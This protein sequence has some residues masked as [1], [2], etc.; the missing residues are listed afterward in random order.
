[1]E[2]SPLCSRP[3]L[4]GGASP[5]S[6]AR[7]APPGRPATDLNVVLP[8]FLPLAPPPVRSSGCFCGSDTGSASK[9]FLCHSS[10]A[11]DVLRGAVRNSTCI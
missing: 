3:G 10:A 7:A 4:V 2:L 5:V 8:R 6:S 11:Q 9:G 1:M